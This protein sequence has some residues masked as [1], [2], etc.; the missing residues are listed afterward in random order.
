V[1]SLSSVDALGFV[2]SAMTLVAFAQRAMLPMRLAAIAANAF[3]IA[4]GVMGPY[5]PVLVLHLV[6][7]PANVSRLAE[8]VGSSKN[9]LVDLWKEEANEVFHVRIRSSL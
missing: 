4:Y 1:L 8:Q 5:Y 2:A 6:L 7:L 9:T 3:F